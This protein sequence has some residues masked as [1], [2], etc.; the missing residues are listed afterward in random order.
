M[1]LGQPGFYIRGV[2]C[3][4]GKGLLSISYGLLWGAVACYCKLLGF[5][6][7]PEVD[8][9]GGQG[10]PPRDEGLGWYVHPGVLWRLTAHKGRVE[11]VEH[12]DKDKYQCLFE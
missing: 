1:H 4:R 11:L 8:P 6:G 12:R 2:F 5:P 3:I 10:P 7:G 9:P